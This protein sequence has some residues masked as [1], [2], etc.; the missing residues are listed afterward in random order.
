[1]SDL[2]Q[3]P[4]LYAL[5]LLRRINR[6]S[7][8][9]RFEVFTRDNYT[10]QY[11]GRNVREHKVVLVVDHIIPKKKGGSDDFANLVTACFEC[12]A[13]K[14]AVFHEKLISNFSS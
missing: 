12:N 7:L 8:A 11:C 1:M 3:S 14:R 4:N 13:G 6:V 2:L 9:Q 5:G 10:C